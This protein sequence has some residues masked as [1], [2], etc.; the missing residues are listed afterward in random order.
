MPPNTGRIQS[1]DA[2]YHKLGTAYIADYRFLLGDA[3]APCIYRTDAQNLDENPNDG[4]K[5]HRPRTSPLAW[6]A[7]IPITPACS[8]PAPSSASTSHSITEPTGR[9]FQMNLPVTPVTDIKVA[10]KDPITYPGRSFWILDNLTP[11]HQM[12]EKTMTESQ[13]CAP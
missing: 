7:K 6:D 2:S 8:M 9:S 4:K 12:S 5:R 3:K 1:I 13:L 10:H 11:L